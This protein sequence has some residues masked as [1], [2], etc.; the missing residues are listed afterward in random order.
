MMQVRILRTVLFIGMLLSMSAPMKGAALSNASLQGNYF[1]VQEEIDTSVLG[2]SFTTVQGNLSFDQSGK[3]AVLG[4]INH[5]GSVQNISLSGTYS[6]QSSGVVQVSLPDLSFSVTGNVSFDLNSIVATNVASRS[7]LVHQIFLATKQSASPLFPGILNGKYFL[8][9]RTITASGSTHSLENSSGTITFDGQRNATIQL[10]SHQNNAVTSVNGQ[11]TYQI[12]NDGTVSLTLPGK[13]APLKFGF[14]PDGYMGVGAT[15]QLQSSGT[16]D[17]YTITKAANEGLGNAGLNGSYAIIADTYNNNAGLGN[18]AATADYLGNGTVSYQSTLNPGSASTSGTVSVDA[19]ANLQFSGFP[20]LAGSFRGWLGISGNTFTA[21]SLDDLASYNF[22]VAVR[23]PSQPAA[24]LNAASFLAGTLSPGA[25]ISIFGRNLGRQVVQASSLPLPTTLGG[26]SVRIGGVA[27]PLL[28][29][30]P[31]QVNVQ[32][33]FE[34]PPSQVPLSVVLDGVESGPLTITVN[35]AGPGIFTVSSDG[36]GTGIF[37]HGSD[38]SL[39]TRSNPAHPGEVVLIYGTSLGAVLPAVVSGNAAPSDTL[40][41]ATGSVSVQINGIDAGTPLFASLAP[42]FVGLYQLNVQI[43]G[44]I[45]TAG[46]LSVVVTAS[47]VQSKTVTIPVAA[48]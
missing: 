20:G 16:H 31:F 27:A 23:T 24:V 47:G 4:A 22:L 12:L 6:L 5:D 37:L 14:S 41:T 2:F 38:F 19:D 25:L 34:V 33:P 30:S 10:S 18:A 9:E 46:D 36:N 42:G 32:M 11:A 3:I 35:N 39:V 40:A 17:L 1:F 45:Q 26:V 8:A 7:S 13:N 15:V 48:P 29:V 44:A 21:A 28:F 43:P